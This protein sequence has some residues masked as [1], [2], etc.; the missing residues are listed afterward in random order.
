[1]ERTFAIIKPDAVERKLAGQILA[2][3]EEAGFTVRAMR[4]QHLTKRLWAWGSEHGNERHWA[5]RI[6]ARIAARGA[7]NFWPDL[8]A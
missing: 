3:I 2:R 4:L 6:G 7:V 1:M 5:D 8:T